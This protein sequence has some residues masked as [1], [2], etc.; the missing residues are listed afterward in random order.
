[1]PFVTSLV[2]WI[3]IFAFAVIVAVLFLT[4]VPTGCVVQILAHGAL[5]VAGA[6]MVLGLRP[7]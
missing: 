7:R 1:M 4:V 6:A 3:W 2:S 5:L